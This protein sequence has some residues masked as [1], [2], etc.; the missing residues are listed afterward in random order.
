M[1]CMVKSCYLFLWAYSPSSLYSFYY[2]LALSA[3]GILNQEMKTPPCREA[4]FFV[5]KEMKED[6]CWCTRKCHG[7]TQV[8][9]AKSFPH[10]NFLGGFRIAPKYLWGISLTCGCEFLPPNCVIVIAYR[11]SCNQY[12][13]QLQ[14]QIIF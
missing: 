12:I 4:L 11:C 13:W 8:R 1:P 14:S 9:L 2:F 5:A 10:R 3:L 7:S 6:W